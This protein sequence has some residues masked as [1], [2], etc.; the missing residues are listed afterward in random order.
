MPPVRQSTDYSQPMSAAGGTG[1]QSVLY[2]F[3]DRLYRSNSLN[4]VFEAAL[5]AIC[6]GL[7]CERASILLFDAAGVMRFVAWRGLSET[8]RKAVDGHSPWRQGQINPEPIFVGDVQLDPELAALLPIAAAEN[9]RSLAFIP[10]VEGNATIGK[11]MT[12]YTR[13]HDFSSEESALGLTIAIPLIICVAAINIRI[14]KLE[15]L[16]SAALTRFFDTF[17]AKSVDQL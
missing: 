6:R 15:D 1:D 9:I 11:F 8:Y 13:P 5:E 14:R 7:K 4:E 12:Y 2:E 3:T 10:I 17:K 16:V